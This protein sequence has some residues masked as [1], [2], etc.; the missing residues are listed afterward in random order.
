MMNK[1]KVVN[2]NLKSVYNH[3][4]EKKMSTFGP[5]SKTILARFPDYCWTMGNG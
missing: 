2:H 5:I 4:D 1:F 3:L